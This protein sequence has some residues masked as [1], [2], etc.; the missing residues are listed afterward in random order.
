MDRYWAPFS[1]LLMKDTSELAAEERVCVA[2][3]EAWRFD[4][5]GGGPWSQARSWCRT[6]RKVAVAARVLGRMPM[7]GDPGVSFSQVRWIERQRRE[8]LNA[9]Q[10][11]R[12]EA[13]PYWPDPW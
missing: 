13:I 1:D 9:F 4:L 3:Y 12:V 10:R 2:F 6:P 5:E 7:R 8:P 11:A